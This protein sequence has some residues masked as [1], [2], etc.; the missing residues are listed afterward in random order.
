ME[1]ENLFRARKRIMNN[2]LFIKIL[3]FLLAINSITP[4][5]AETNNS[6]NASENSAATAVA[7]PA[8][9]TPAAPEI[10]K[11][12]LERICSVQFKGLFFIKH[13]LDAVAVLR[14]NG[15]DKVLA[16][17]FQWIDQQN[18][19]LS[20]LTK[21]QLAAHIVLYGAIAD[22][23][24]EIL[25]KKDD[26]IEGIT[27]LDPNRLL[28]EL[29]NTITAEVTNNIDQVI[30]LV[31]NKLNM[32]IT[33]V[34]KDHQELL[35]TVI[36]QQRSQLSRLQEILQLIVIKIG[37]SKL[38]DK[39]I[40]KER[41][42]ELR[43][44][45]QKAYNLINQEGATMTV[46]QQ[47]H[48]IIKAIT[49]ELQ[50]AENDF[51]D[52]QSLDKD[53]ITR[54]V[55]AAQSLD[56]S[57]LQKESINL[58]KQIEKLETKAELA[59]LT[60]H[61]RTARAVSDY[62]I[63]PA[64]RHRH[65]FGLAVGLTGL[66]VSAGYIF[67]LP[68]FKWTEKLFGGPFKLLE[69]EHTDAVRDHRAPPAGWLSKN[70]N[71]LGRFFPVGGAM[72]PLALFFGLTAYSAKGAW[73]EYRLQEK[74]NN[75]LNYLKGGSYRQ[76]MLKKTHG[77]NP[78]T[79]DDVIGMDNAKAIIRQ[80]L[81][82]LKNPERWVLAGVNLPTALLFTGDT[83]SGKT[84]F[85]N[86]VR[87]EATRA[88]I[89]NVQFREI[90]HDL[91]RDYGIK[92]IFEMAKAYWA[93]CILFIDEAHLL[94]LQ[95]TGD[96][97]VYS[98]M[99]TALSGLDVPDP[100]RP[101]I[102]IVATNK[103]ENLGAPLRQKGR[104]QVEIH[105]VYPSVA[106]RLEFLLHKLSF[107]GID[108][109]TF[110]IDV[111]KIARETENCTYEMLTSIISTA[112]IQI[113]M[114]GSTLSQEAL[115]RAMDTEIRKIIFYDNKN[116]PAAEKRFLAAYW[117]GV[118]VAASELPDAPKISAVT[119]TP[120]MVNVKEEMVGADL[121][122]LSQENDKKEKQETII[123][124]KI[125]TYHNN[126]TIGI[127]TE[128]ERVAN[129]KIYLAGRAAEKLLCG[130][131][132]SYYSSRRQW[133][134]EQIKSLICRGLDYSKLSKKAQD[135]IVDQAQALLAQYEQ[136]AEALIAPHKTTIEIVAE[137]LSSDEKINGDMLEAVIAHV[138]KEGPKLLDELKALKQAS[139]QPR[140]AAPSTPNWLGMIESATA[141][142]AIAA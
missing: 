34:Q 87:G 56:F 131:T 29:Q 5:V 81:N 54:S 39:A 114:A 59:S 123:R 60:W 83:R 41:V 33:I 15:A 101:V 86:A 2:R 128:V 122:G 65:C 73:T 61:E 21:E 108:P 45:V 140:S 53:T 31:N 19:T 20:S 7:Q 77:L 51:S 63:S 23:F 94:H 141:D 119:I 11:E 110:N 44:Q 40:L 70:L 3:A 121:F 67:D 66:G 55:S 69:E 47:L 134:F 75:L 78:V 24:G 4:I 36:T 49:D 118:C 46:V 27:C 89:A 102:L 117:A 68:G 100:K 25:E 22:H 57:R 126:D 93:P 48:T 113:N 91:I 112:L 111:A 76:Q 106:E 132:S 85:A 129:I 125:W 79:F 84:H 13:L 9:Q 6:T 80:I 71:K 97:K 116:I 30:E 127:E 28:E 12:T 98:E 135:D 90:T 62:I 104:L 107:Y 42:M 14:N 138:K 37:Q 32:V 95:D 50:D 105:F 18:P 82:F 130:T 58:S 72:F 96:S 26:K 16:P 38:A 99:L 92:T 120:V 136:E 52:V 43:S 74:L 115:E 139:E 10:T 124:G 17:T 142:T 109:R 8:V 137:I 1:L 133:A 64:Y 103:P 88:G 35:S